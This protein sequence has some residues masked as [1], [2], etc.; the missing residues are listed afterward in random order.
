MTHA[1]KGNTVKVNYEGRLQDGRVFDSS[2][3]HDEPLEFTVGEG[4]VI[5][6]FEE[7]VVGM[8]VGESKEVTVPSDKAY[9][10]RRDELIG[11][12]KREN[13]PEDID[14]KVGTELQVKM[15]NGVVI[16]AVVVGLDD[17][18]VTIDANHPLAGED[19]TFDIELV[20]VH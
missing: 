2:S 5:P 20:E 15:D 16:P 10:E 4:K 17:N 18:T 1:E 9:G 12:V 6:G 14:L 7:A 11:N 13:V 8:A 19:L 3:A